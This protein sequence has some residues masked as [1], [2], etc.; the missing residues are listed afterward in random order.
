MS[1]IDDKLRKWSH[2]FY[3]LLIATSL[4]S[5]IRIGEQVDVSQILFGVY[6]EGDLRNSFVSSLRDK[7]VKRDSIRYTPNARFKDNVLNDIARPAFID[8]VVLFDDLSAE[9][10]QANGFVNVPSEPGSKAAYVKKIIS[11]RAPEKLWSANG[12]IQLRLYATR[13]FTMAVYGMSG[14]LIY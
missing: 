11:E 4:C 6:S 12:L 3:R 1:K 9:I 5:S 13:L 2:S 7:E 14:P 8:L 10:L